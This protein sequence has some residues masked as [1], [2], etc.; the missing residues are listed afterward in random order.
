MFGDQSA[1]LGRVIQSRETNT[2]QGRGSTYSLDS[3]S[4]VFVFE[5]DI[6]E[7][8]ILMSAP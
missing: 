8:G 6:L 3:I 1:R 5:D 7:E 2:T 4:S